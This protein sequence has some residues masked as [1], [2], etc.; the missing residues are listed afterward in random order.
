MPRTVLVVDDHAGF[1]TRARLLLEAEGYEVVGEA[2]DGQTAV[3][4]ARRLHPDVVLLDVQLPDVDGFDVAA[5]ITGEGGE[6]ITGD[7]VQP[8]VVLTS[9]RDWSDSPELILRSGAKGFLPKDQ[10]SGEAV[11]ELLR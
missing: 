2:A 7:D 3:A 4:E 9:S 11:G 8:A 10:L 5:R 1:R 6:L